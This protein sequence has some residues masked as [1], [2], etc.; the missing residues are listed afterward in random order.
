M[1]KYNFYISF[2]D[3]L[4][5]A[6]TKAIEDC[7]QILRKCGY[8]DLTISITTKTRK[9]YLW[10]VLKSFV[11]LL[12]SVQ[13]QSIVAVQYPILSGNAF[14]KYIISLLRFKKVK[15][16]CIIHDLDELR[17]NANI[18]DK[19]SKEVVLLNSYDFIIVHN[20]VMKRWLLQKGVKVP[21]TAL[22]IFDY[23]SN[24]RKSVNLLDTKEN[25]KSL[26]FAGNL[27]KSKFIYQLGK[28]D[29]WHCNLYG[30]GFLHDNEDG[31][32]NVFWKGSL[33]AN[34]ILNRMEGAFGLIWD[35]D[36]IE[37]LDDK[38]GNYLK[39]N[40][41]HKLSLYLAAGLPVIAPKESA[42]SQFILQ[43]NLGILIN[44]ILELKDIAIDAT[45]YNLY[46]TS[47][48]GISDQVKKGQY[49]E[50]AIVKAEEFLQTV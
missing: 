9:L 19:S 11:N 32:K 18:D 38:Y 45:Q 40:N 10:Y 33:S 8:E 22:Q 3:K 39:Y 14:F 25:L 41:P 30:P 13:P 28:L 16:F 44:N 43:N 12:F 48:R 34:K 46:K 20:E 37:K 24:Y 2:N 49:F 21:M 27:A 29:N 26:V 7:K 1:H 35:G 42:I 36:N 50:D 31:M 23:L 15:F 5:T 17:Y 6:A 4:N 47:V